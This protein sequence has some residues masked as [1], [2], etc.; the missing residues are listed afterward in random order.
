M[1]EDSKNSLK[2]L[3][4]L[5]GDGS[6]ENANKHLYSFRNHRKTNSGYSGEENAEEREYA[7]DSE[8]TYVDS[9]YG[10]SQ[11]IELQPG[12]NYNESSTEPELAAMSKSEKQEYYRHFGSSHPNYGINI[13]SSKVG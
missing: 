8:R 2:E 10:T 13:S 9:I 12:F 7:P 6:N 5:T 11:N 3:T 4:G 1:L